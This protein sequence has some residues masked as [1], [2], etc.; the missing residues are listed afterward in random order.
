MPMDDTPPIDTIERE[1][2]GVAEELIVRWA[3]GDPSLEETTVRALERNRWA[4]EERE[5]WE[6][7]LSVI[8][9][10]AE[11]DRGP[12]GMSAHL[13]SL[14]RRRVAARNAFAQATG[15]ARGRIV[16]V[17]N[18][19]GPGAPPAGRLRSPLA[20]ALSAECP[21]TADIWE[22]WI[23]VPQNHIA[24]VTCW[25]MLLEEEKDGPFDPNAAVV[26]LWNPVRIHVARDS[27]TVGQ[28]SAA[29][30][31]AARA[32][33]EEFAQGLPPDLG[34][35]RPGWFGVRWVRG[36]SVVTGTRLGGRHDP[37]R[38]YQRLYSRAAA[39][40]SLPAPMPAVDARAGAMMSRISRS[41][42]QWAADMGVAITTTAPVAQ[43]MGTHE[44]ERIYRL[45]KHVELRLCLHGEGRVVHLHATAVQQEPV[46]L[47]L[48][49]GDELLQSARL[50]REHRTADFFFDIGKEHVLAIHADDS[51]ARYQIPLT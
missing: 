8:E 26:Q 1:L 30:L 2:F 20:V 27:V 49:Q 40:V 18:A 16:L 14:I 45:G 17:E 7:D 43:P 44:K 13:E 15:G 21:G 11:A 51:G 10:A 22:G 38:V 24:Y 50:D 34:P 37:R 3:E 39:M 6:D 9:G 29:T 46:D 23:V 19:E 31:A 41:L 5:R 48:K 32:V 33:S 35:P 4:R 12:V 42:E 36:H 25:D 47:A 28:L